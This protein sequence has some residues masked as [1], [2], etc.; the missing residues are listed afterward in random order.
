MSLRAWKGWKV[1]GPFL[2]RGAMVGGLKVHIYIYIIY[3]YIYFYVY[4]PKKFIYVYLGHLLRPNRRVVTPKMV[5]KSKGILP[6]MA[7]NQVRDF[8]HKLPRYIGY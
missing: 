8:F 3:V 4:E 7:L 1:G 2:G 5:V 6:K